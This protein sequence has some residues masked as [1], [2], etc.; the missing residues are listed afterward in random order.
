MQGTRENNTE[1]IDKEK[2]SRIIAGFLINTLKVK[3]NWGK[4]LQVLEDCACQPRLLRPAKLLAMVEG[5]IKTPPCCTQAER[6]QVHYTSPT[7]TAGSHKW[8]AERKQPRKNG[9]K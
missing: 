4:L 6:I 9:R 8:D 2:P 1:A 3:R 5:G 7:E